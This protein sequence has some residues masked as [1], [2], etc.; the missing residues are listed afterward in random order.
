MQFA[1]TIPQLMAERPHL[2]NKVAVVSFWPQIIYKA[3]GACA[4]RAGHTLWGGRSTLARVNPNSRL[5]IILCS[6]MALS[7]TLASVSS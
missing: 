7:N 1:V 6:R 3:S 4:A 5:Y 2:Y